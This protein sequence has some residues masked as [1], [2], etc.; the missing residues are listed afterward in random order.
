MQPI[1]LQGL[2]YDSLIVYVISIYYIGVPIGVD[3]SPFIANSSPNILPRNSLYGVYRSQLIRY[4][5][6][7]STYTSFN[8][9]TID[10]IKSFI[11]LG[12]KAG[13]L[14]TSYSRIL[15]TR[16]RFGGNLRSVLMILI[17]FLI[18]FRNSVQGVWLYCNLCFI[19]GVRITCEIG[20][21]VLTV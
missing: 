7:C 19:L 10:L 14:K 5:R 20:I 13:L 16:Y 4:F 17:A 8:I 2:I 9:R 12:Y 3:P 18:R 15:Y 6:I 11:D 21:S 1:Y